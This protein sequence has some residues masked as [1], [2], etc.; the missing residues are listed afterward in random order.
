MR[1]IFITLALFAL[2]KVNAQDTILI[3]TN[4]TKPIVNEKVYL[5]FNLNFIEKKLS[6]Q[7]TN[8]VKLETIYNYTSEEPLGEIIKNINNTAVQKEISGWNYTSLISFKESKKYIVGP[9]KFSFGEKQYV[10]NKIIFDVQPM[11][12][13]SELDIKLVSNPNQKIVISQTIFETADANGKTTF[14]DPVDIINNSNIIRFF[15]TS[16]TVSNSL[17][18][19]VDGAKKGNCLKV[20]KEYQVIISPNFSSG[21]LVL[22]KEYFK[23]L[24]DNYQLPTIIIKSNK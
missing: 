2:L 23:N 11:L 15:M 5:R 13:A 7:L 12:T 8:G 19:G 21:E 10:T 1:I 20:K 24:P 22:T 6:K 4:N 14:T 9:F 16:S 17:S 18:Y 3:S